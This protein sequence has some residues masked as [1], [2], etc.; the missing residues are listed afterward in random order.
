MTPIQEKRQKAADIALGA[1][2]EW[3]KEEKRAAAEK[4]DPSKEAREKFDKSMEDYDKLEAEIA[5]LEGDEKR[6]KRIKELAKAP[7]PHSEPRSHSPANDDEDDDLD[8]ILDESI[9][10]TV[11]NHPTSS[12]EYRQAMKG[13]MRGQ[14]AI[15]SKA[16]FRDLQAD[17]FTAGGAAMTPMS[18]AAGILKAVDDDLFMRQ[19]GDV[20]RADTSESMGILS[21]DADPA[22]S[23]WT[24][25]IGTTQSDS[26]MA[27][28][29]REMTP[30]KLSKLIKISNKLLMRTSF[31]IE[32]FVTSRLGYK[33]GVSMEKAY[34]TGDGAKKP[35]GIF[36][37][38]DDGIGTARD[39]TSD[40]ATAISVSDLVS[41][42]TA[43]KMQYS[44]NGSWVFGRA[45]LKQV[46]LMKTTEAYVWQ[47]ALALG[48]PATILD[49]PYYISEYAPNV[50]TAGLYTIVYGDFKYYGICDSL[51]Q[52]IQRLNELY[53]V[54]DQTGYICRMWS[55]G[56][57]LLSEAF[58]RLIQHA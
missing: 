23:D 18:M 27:F 30:H 38:N 45:A 9:E 34:M 25:E 50:I 55:D 21:L 43:V 7:K 4:G 49:R 37:A 44:R 36:V 46:R 19:L 15:P 48:N 12:K 8:S 22:D 58:A 6:S 47:P 3:E 31:D 10:A 24:A 52:S 26:T 11:R 54:T 29:R 35:L 16:E 33:L 13:Y 1:R 41:L 5:V 20:Q 57:P 2:N 39:I 14:R 17:V 56:M 53:A 51:V 40:A 32:G 42:Q 28:G